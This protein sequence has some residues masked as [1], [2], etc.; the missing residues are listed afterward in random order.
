MYIAFVVSGLAV[1]LVVGFWSCVLLVKQNV[2]LRGG[3]V[4]MFLESRDLELSREV[5]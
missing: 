5:N 3:R 1:L 2:T 4:S